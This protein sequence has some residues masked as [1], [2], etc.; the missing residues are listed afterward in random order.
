LLGIV[1]AAI[2][3]HG[4][5]VTSLPD[6]PPAMRFS[7]PHECRKVLEVAGFA[8]V[9]VH[10]VETAWTARQPEALLDLVYGGAVRAAMV[11]E[12][13][14]PARRNLIHGA[15]MRAAKARTLDG[16]VTIRRPVVMASGVRPA[17]R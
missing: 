9:Q 3:E 4:K 2:S 1:L 16:V 11:L 6:A 10:R 13:Q 17:R 7:D 8:E 5:Q 12:A 15:I 14:P